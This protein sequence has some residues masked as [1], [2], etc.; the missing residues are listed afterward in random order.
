M[1]RNQRATQLRKEHDE[2]K[3]IAALILALMCI[4]SM[5][6]CKATDDSQ[7]TEPSF[8]E[9]I[10]D[11]GFDIGVD[12]DTNDGP[13]ALDDNNEILG[14]VLDGGADIGVDAKP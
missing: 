11:G 5:T 13:A 4:L 12:A 8:T 9:G 2:M 1:L 14:G 7:S 6:G 3:K 10:L